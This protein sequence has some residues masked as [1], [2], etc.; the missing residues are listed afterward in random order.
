MAFGR[1]VNK[2]RILGGKIN[3]SLSRVS[4]IVMACARLHN[5]I[6]QRDGPCDVASVGMSTSEEESML[7]ITPDPASPLGMSYLP[8]MPNADYVFEMTDGISHTRQEIVVNKLSKENKLHSIR[9][10][11]EGVY[12]DF[13]HW[14]LLDINPVLC[15]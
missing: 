14:L 1:M 3:G 5:F 10:L 2:F 13:A 12:F 6:I 8:T 7:Q 9:F 15:V 11:V 4:K